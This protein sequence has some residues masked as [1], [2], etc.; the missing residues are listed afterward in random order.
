ML[1]FNVVELLPASSSLSSVSGS[2]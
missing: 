2:S 1:N